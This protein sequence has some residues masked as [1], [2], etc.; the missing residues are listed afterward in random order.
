MNPSRIRPTA[1]PPIPHFKCGDMLTPFIHPGP[2]A[3]GPA[4]LLLA[5]SPLAHPVDLVRTARPGQSTLRAY[6]IMTDDRFLG[7]AP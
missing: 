6:V 2:G 5:Y 1:T 4:Q 3:P 7:R